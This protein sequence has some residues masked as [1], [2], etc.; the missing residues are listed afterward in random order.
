MHNGGI[1]MVVEFRVLAVSKE[2]QHYDT[3]LIRGIFSAEHPMLE[4]VDHL[5]ANAAITVVTQC[6][7]KP[8]VKEAINTPT[9]ILV[10]FI[11]Q[12]LE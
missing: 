9:H 12:K 3:D 8:T 2:T 11:G 7:W 10:P 4:T 6:N 1:A 5:P